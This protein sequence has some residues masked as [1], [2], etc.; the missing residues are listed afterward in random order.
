M[1]KNIEDILKYNSPVDETNYYNPAKLVKRAKGIYIWMDGEEE[2]YIDLLMGYS[3]TNFGH[4]NDDILK[5]AKE[6]IEKFDNVT[7]FNS[8]DKIELTEKLINLLP[9]PG[10]K[11]VYYPVGGTKAVDAAIKLAF[12]FTKK[13]EIISFDGAFHGYS[14]AGMSVTDKRYVNKKQYGQSTLNVKFFPFPNKLHATEEESVG[15]LKDIDNYL[16][17]NS[18]RIAAVIIEPIQG[19]A[20][21]HMPHKSFLVGLD[22][23]T[24]KY[25]I[26]FICDEIQ[27]GVYRT[28]TFYYIN[29]VNIDPD[30]ILLGKSLAGGYYP[31]SAVIGRRELFENIPLDGSGFDSTFANNL[32]GLRIANKAIYFMLKKKINKRVEKTGKK[33]L[34]KLQELQKYPFI[35]DISGIGMAFSFSVESPENTIPTNAKL[36]KEIK[37]EAF[38]NHLIIQTAGVNGDYIKLSPSFFISDE[39]IDISVKRLNKIMELVSKISF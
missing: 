21:F 22:K 20:G 39:E 5:F 18:K 36:A 32:L 15:I 9:H 23:L 8:R 24:K 17:K 12:A 7:S 38:I 2:P 26:I 1:R 25:K 33:F 29:Q 13:Q 37:K 31:L 3:S 11:L 27:I 30:I 10:K 6:A 16:R 19:A 28:G 14:F 34:E 35:E 4:A